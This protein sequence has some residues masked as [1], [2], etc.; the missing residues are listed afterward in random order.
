MSRCRQCEGTVTR[1]SRGIERRLQK[2]AR[3]KLAPWLL[4]I[5]ATRR[6]ALDD[7]IEQLRGNVDHLFHLA[8]IYDMTA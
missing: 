2:F 4:A 7:D 8:A 6:A 1:L 5:V 3:C